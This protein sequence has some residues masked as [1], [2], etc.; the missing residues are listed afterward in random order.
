MI[1]TLLLYLLHI[2]SYGYPNYTVD[3][4]TVVINELS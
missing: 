1:T 4:V 3:I 2:M